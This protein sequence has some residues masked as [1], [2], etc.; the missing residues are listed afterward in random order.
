MNTTKREKVPF[1]SGATECVA[2]HYPADNG[3]ASSWRAGW[4]SPRSRPRTCPV[5][6]QSVVHGRGAAKRVWRRVEQVPTD[7]DSCTPT[8]RS[9]C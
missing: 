6:S 1:A 5:G 4:R 7:K 8:A 3:P 9:C 2:W